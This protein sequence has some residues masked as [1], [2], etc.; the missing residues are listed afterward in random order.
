MGSYSSQSYSCDPIK[1]NLTRSDVPIAVNCCGIAK[2]PQGMKT[3]PTV[4]RDV[5]LIYM[6]CG[7]LT[8][9]IDGRELTLIAGDY[10][11]I[12]PETYY[13]YC[14]TSAESVRYF[15]IHFTG[16]EVYSVLDR[17]GITPLTVCHSAPAPQNAE[18][19][20]QLFSEFRSRHASFTYR[21]E[22]ILRNILMR[23]TSQ[24][25]DAMPQKSPIDT[26]LRYI[27]THISANITVAAL[28]EMEYLSQGYYRALFKSVT[29]TSPSEYVAAYRIVR[30]GELLAN[31]SLSIDKIAESIG[32]SDRL[33][34]QRFFKKHTGTTPAEYRRMASSNP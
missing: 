24:T 1:N 31:T 11:C 4:R 19:Y 15:W 25:S 21:T 6:I 28:A 22:L 18:L 17:T 23:L 3:T 13:S 20:E 9:F 2:L 10:I 5:Y 7:E 30:A 29:G 14:C 27:H 8:A 26:S 34:F 32:I 33:Y 16:G 12:P